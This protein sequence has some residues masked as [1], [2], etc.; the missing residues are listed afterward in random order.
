MPTTLTVV[1]HVKV[2]AGS[3]H[4]VGDG[5]TK[6]PRS[7]LLRDRAGLSQQICCRPP[8]G[9]GDVALADAQK[10]PPWS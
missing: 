3:A 1:D 5:R 2:Y 7:Q 8:V 9:G 6:R 10:S 4:D